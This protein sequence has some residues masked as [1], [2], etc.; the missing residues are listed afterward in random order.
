MSDVEFWVMDS[1]ECPKIICCSND[2]GKILPIVVKD[3]IGCWRL[4][5]PPP[6]P[7]SSP[8]PPGHRGGRDPKQKGMEEVFEQIGAAVQ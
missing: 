6:P 8:P 3:K 5:S 7:P 2:G 4:I 1:G